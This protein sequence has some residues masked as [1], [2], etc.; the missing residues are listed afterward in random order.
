MNKDRHLCKKCKYRGRD[1]G[2]YYT[3]CDY[4]EITGHSRGC[5]VEECD[6]YERGKKLK[7]NKHANKNQY[8]G[9]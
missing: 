1:Q 2:G 3:T 8:G 5:K 7:T 9:Y 6:K 4:I